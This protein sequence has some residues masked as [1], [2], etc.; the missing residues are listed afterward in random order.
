MVVAL[1]PNGE[2][3]VSGCEDGAVRV[4]NRLSGEQRPMVTGRHT[5]SVMAVAVTPDGEEV[6]SGGHGGGVRVWNSRGPICPRCSDPRSNAGIIPLIPGEGGARK[7]T[8]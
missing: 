4:W 5:G 1:T 8:A 7:P 6:V 2:E 3:V